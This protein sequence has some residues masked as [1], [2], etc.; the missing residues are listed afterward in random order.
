MKKLAI[1]G[2]EPVFTREDREPINAIRQWPIITEEDEAAALEV[3]RTNNFSNTDITEKF[4]AEFAAWNQ[5]KHAVAYCNGTMAL[6]AAMFGI[7]LGKGDE[8]ICTTKTYWAS[9]VPATMFGA[10]PVFCNV[11]EMISMDPTDL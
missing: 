3:I 6:A 11:D 8:I 1:L 5:T 4:E 7:G 10:V 9:V 2:G